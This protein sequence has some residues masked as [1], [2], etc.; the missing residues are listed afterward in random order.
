MKITF[1]VSGTIRSNFTYRALAF[2][3]SLN[4]L[5]HTVSIIA[6]SADK[7]NDFRR[8][9]INS[10][11]GVKILQPFQ[12][13]TRKPELNLLPYLFGAAKMALSE[14]PDL[15]I[16]YKPT[17]VN[18]VGFIVKLFCGTDTIMDM[19]DLGSEVMRI[20]E[21]PWYQRKLVAWS[22]R[23]ALRYSD[24]IS[25][26]SSYLFNAYRREFPNKPI[27]I[28]PNGVEADWFH[29]VTSSQKKEGIVFMGS[30]NRRNILEP[31]FDALPAIIKEHP[32]LSVAIIGGGKD[33][34]YFRQKGRDAMIDQRLEFTGWLDI[35][36]ARARLHAG[37]I[38]YN[39]MPDDPTT[40]AA[41]NMKVSQYMARGVVPLVSKIGDLPAMV[42]FG[43]AGYLCDAGSQAAL[44]A[45]L[46]HAL[47]DEDRL[48]KA[49]RARALAAEK[50]GWD[51]LASGFLQWLITEK[52]K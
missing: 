46:R 2:A 35:A 5:G 19:D 12:F 4:K 34:E 21:H 48:H 30:I 20:E 37:D 9:E 16:M 52:I 23:F 11:Q 40:K 13:A 33:L 1:L 15:V 49:E 50:F 22:E 41:N 36:D 28:M 43:T 6:P 45:G 26:A 7:Y 31:L 47:K 25:V 32:D 3:R 27:H 39:Y 51:N 44:G 14:R 38:G 10:I 17:P 42:D 18:V 29:P 24:G 8:E